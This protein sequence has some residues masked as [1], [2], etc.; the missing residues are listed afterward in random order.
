MQTE[1]GSLGL[2]CHL[3]SSSRVPLEV[4]SEGQVSC[5]GPHRW[6]VPEAGLKCPQLRAPLLAPQQRLG[7]DHMGRVTDSEL[8]ILGGQPALWAVMAGST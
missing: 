5:R 2:A 4:G 1:K 7:Q 8:A 3:I 6:E